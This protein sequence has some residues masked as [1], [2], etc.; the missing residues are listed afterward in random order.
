MCLNTFVMYG[1][2]LA[3]FITF[4]YLCLWVL[5]YCFKQKRALNGLKAGF[6][7]VLPSF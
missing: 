6:E 7:Y 3:V 5:E 2:F 1:C 4:S